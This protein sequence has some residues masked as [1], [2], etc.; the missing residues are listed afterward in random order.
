M[1]Q[2]NITL[3][4]S[5][6]PVQLR[7]GAEWSEQLVMEWYNQLHRHTKDADHLKKNSRFWECCK[8]KYT[9]RCDKMEDTVCFPHL[10]GEPVIVSPLHRRY[11]MTYQ[12]IQAVEADCRANERKL[13]R[14]KQVCQAMVEEKFMPMELLPP[15]ECT[16]T[17]A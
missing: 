15:P 8:C 16:E 14:F 2:D 11:L 13:H 6:V 7:Q 12:P 17:E 1:S 4:F 9:A 3:Q 10:G 5:E